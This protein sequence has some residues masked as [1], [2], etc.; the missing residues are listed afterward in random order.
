MIT[1][2]QYAYES[3]IKQWNPIV[4]MLLSMT[5]LFTCVLVSNNFFSLLVF[6]FM[7]WACIGWSGL[8][9]KT[10]GKLCCI[11]VGFLIIGVLTIAV[12]FPQE[13]VGMVNLAFFSRYIAIT[14]DGLDLAVNIFLKSM[15]GVSC[16]YFLYVS[17]PVS[18]ILGVFDKMKV[19]QILT[20]MMMM[21]YRFIFILINTMEQMMVASKSRLGNISYGRQLKTMAAM[22][23]SVFVNSFKR[24]TDI[25][26]AMES[27]GY[28]GAMVYTQDLKLA[29]SRQKTV[30]VCY[31][32]CMLSAAVLLKYVQVV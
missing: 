25:L 29:T 15:A 5:T 9:W 30:L 8:G 27:R 24:S 31:E 28:D 13:P 3:K 16:L 6:F 23:T 20:E 18:E 11:P 26:N 21:I 4:K 12:S 1:M 7:A 17:T 22:S 19:P 2:D 14:R 10:F 32:V